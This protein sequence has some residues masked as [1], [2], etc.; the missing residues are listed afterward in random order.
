[1]QQ[2]IKHLFLERLDKE[3]LDKVVELIERLP[4]IDEE[5]FIFRIMY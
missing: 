1:M 5:D 3:N 4:W 2:Y